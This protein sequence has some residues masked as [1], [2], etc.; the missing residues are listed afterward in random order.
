VST[1]LHIDIVIV[2]HLLLE[3]LL[4]LQNQNAINNSSNYYI[5]FK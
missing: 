1:E 2:I 3:L 5:N 4:V